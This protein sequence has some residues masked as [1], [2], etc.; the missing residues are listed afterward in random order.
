MSDVEK[1]IAEYR[2][3]KKNTTSLEYYRA[4]REEIIKQRRKR[5]GKP[6]DPAIP[7]PQGAPYMDDA[8]IVRSYNN[9]VSQ[10]KQIKILAQLN[11][12]TVETIEK[13]LERNGIYIK[14]KKV[15]KNVCV[16]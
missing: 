12:V 8:E 16:Q 6:I 2:R 7:K 13:I 5:G 3:R 11:G 15:K 9:A 1:A 10:K 14:Q 4:H